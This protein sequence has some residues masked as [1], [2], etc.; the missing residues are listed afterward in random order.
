MRD[1]VK[2]QKAKSCF[3]HEEHEEHEEMGLL[4]MADGSRLLE[5]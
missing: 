1:E 4:A 2:N 5:T 3:N